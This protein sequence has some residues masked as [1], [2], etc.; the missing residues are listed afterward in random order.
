MSE[1]VVQSIADRPIIDAIATD[2]FMLIGDVS[3][4]NTI[5][6]VTVA[7][8]MTFVVAGLPTPSPTPSPTPQSVFGS[9]EPQILGNDSGGGYTVGMR[10]KATR[11]GF[12]N[13]IRFYKSP[14]ETG[15]HVG[16]IWNSSRDKLVE[17]N[18][19]DSSTSGWKEQALPTPL[20]IAANTT[21]IVSVNMNSK[22]PSTVYP[23]IADIVSGDL[24]AENK[25]VYSQVENFPDQD[26]GNGSTYFRDVIFV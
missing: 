19:P 9:T 20:A 15:S 25:G 22:Y 14:N 26:E 23:S 8:L 2:D 4:G 13:A 11:S 12:I 18:F 21:Y 5:K 16:R 1:I 3:D 6:R 10:F 7:T 17:I 24:I